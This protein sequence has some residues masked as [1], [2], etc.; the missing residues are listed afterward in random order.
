MLR[1]SNARAV[2][3]AF[4]TQFALVF[5]LMKITES[6]HDISSLERHPAPVV[7]H[8]L[9]TVCREGE[10]RIGPQVGRDLLGSHLIDVESVGFE[11]GIR[12][13]KPGLHLVP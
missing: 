10:L 13:F 2:F 8:N 12:G 4:K 11:R 6:G 3:R 7:W 5:T 1:F 9:R